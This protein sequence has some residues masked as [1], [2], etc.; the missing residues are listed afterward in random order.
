ML[1][2]LVAVRARQAG[3]IKGLGGAM[4]FGA[5]SFSRLG[6]LTTKVLLEGGEVRGIFVQEKP[7]ANYP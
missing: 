6:R 7:K 5:P 2:D 1:A 3:A 4:P